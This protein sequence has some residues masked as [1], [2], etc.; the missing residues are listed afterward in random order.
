MSELKLKILNNELKALK[1]KK[2]KILMA[3]EIMKMRT[4][5]NNWRFKKK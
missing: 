5:K 1:E 2:G 4:I 3:M